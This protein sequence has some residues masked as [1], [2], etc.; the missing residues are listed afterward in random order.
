MTRVL[1]VEDDDLVR[2]FLCEVLRGEGYEALEA[3]D[4]RKALRLFDA[5]PVDLVITDLCM[6]E[7]EG[8]ET[9]RALRARNRTVKILAVSGAFG[10]M[11]LP[12]AAKL[13]AN[14]TLSKPIGPAELVR[15]VG[16]M[17]RA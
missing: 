4:G 16:E 10:G 11:L 14:A 17:L 1:V 5:D 8:I 3:E 9:M 15:T 13:G 12:V 2:K 6:P 7:S